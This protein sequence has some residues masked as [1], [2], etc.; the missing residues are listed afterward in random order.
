MSDI[1]DS[2]TAG[3]SRRGGA[4]PALRIAAGIA[5]FAACFLACDRLLVT[6]LKPLVGGYYGALAMKVF[7]VK[8]G[9]GSGEGE[10]LIFGSS[11]TRRAMAY[12]RLSP[13]LHM[14]ILIEAQAGV[15]PRYA[16]YFYKKYR[17]AVGRPRLVM[18]GIDYFEFEKESSL[19]FLA[20]QGLDASFDILD[21]EGAVNPAS[22]AASRLSWLFRLKPRLDDFWAD[23]M[24][25]ERTETDAGPA[26]P[27]PRAGPDEDD[28][29]DAPAAPEAEPAQ[30]KYVPFPGVEGRFLKAL[31][32]DLDA[33]GIPAFLVIIPDH[34]DTQAINHER[35][36]FRRD[37]RS[38]A[39]GYRLVRVLDLDQPDKFPLDDATLFKEGAGPRS[40]C[41]LG[42]EGA[43]VFSDALAREAKEALN[44]LRRIA[45]S[46][47]G[48]R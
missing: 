7:P 21:P 18:L 3:K 35:D 1:A 24:K 6:G 2:E 30:R 46:G 4:S 39:A 31:L 11:R 10:A 29:G 32:D 47:E 9:L 15:Y 5:L 45:R 38:L 40:N 12:E 27:G 14:R 13:V 25:F 44:D 33:E 20:Q 43:I 22:P 19:R 41:H 37:L 36:L 34:I 28:E 48:A 23:V 42:T 17:Q 26:S 8:Q 16:Y